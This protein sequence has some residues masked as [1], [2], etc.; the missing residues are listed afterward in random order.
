[1][2]DI[3]S[4]DEFTEQYVAHSY[5]GGEDT[6][7]PVRSLANPQEANVLIKKL[8]LRNDD[9]TKYYTSVSLQYGPEAVIANELGFKYKILKQE[10]TPTEADWLTVSSGNEVEFDDI[11]TESLASLTFVPFWVRL[12]IPRSTP[13]GIYSEARLIIT[14][15]ESSII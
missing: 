11:G 2:L 6:S 5:V 3:Y 13:Q 1:M 14:Y 15:T 12:E 8:Y 9:P 4:Y 7:Y 10:N